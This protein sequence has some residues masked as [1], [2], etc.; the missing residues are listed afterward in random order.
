VRVLVV[1]S[2]YPPHSLGGYELSCEDVVN[3]W[4]DAGHQVDVLATSTT[5]GEAAGDEQP[6]VHRVLEWYWADHRIEH[7]PTTRRLAIE[8]ANQR[9]LRELIARCHPEVVSFWAMGGMSLGLITACVERSYPVTFVVEDDW[10]CY[11]PKAD[12]WL[13]GWSS[14][15][16]WLRELAGQLLG[17]PTA[18]PVLPPTAVVTFASDYLRQHAAG[19]GLIR[20][21]ASEV[22]PLGTDPTD[23]PSRRPG[24]R[25]WRGRLIA[26]GRVEPRKG[27]DTAIRALPE[28][29]GMTLR[30]VGPGVEG[31]VAELG[32][33]AAELGVGERL[34]FA[35]PLPRH[36]LAAA[37]A[38][39][40]AF[41]FPSRWDE[42]F[43]IV[44]LEAMT[45]ALPVVATRRG[46][47]AE[48]LTDGLNC[49]EV[50]ADDP[51]ALAAAVRALSTDES[52][53][54]RLV[55]GGL[56]T[57]AAYRIDGFAERLEQI[58]LRAAGVAA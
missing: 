22:V 46:G 34:S 17:L 31:H 7:P 57:R 11:G 32:A 26:A 27:F 44:P 28:L 33:L 25:P 2:L 48:F 13:R 6:H 54:R 42:P 9:R 12:A 53:R 43:G 39:A 8:R 24:D 1:T 18:G 23:F 35:G 19:E 58:H 10:F 38:E 29:P 51:A 41:L 14:R 36:E 30:I 47:S 56:T 5:F 52:L 16:A 4:L 21:S 40:D 3:R 50:P 15:P 55:N 49:L 20:F 45:Q 37:Y